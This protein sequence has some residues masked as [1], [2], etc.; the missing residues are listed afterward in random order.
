MPPALVKCLETLDVLMMWSTLE[1]RSD[2]I[3]DSRLSLCNRIQ[4]IIFHTN[5][6]LYK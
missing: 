5:F 4:T 6:Q 2:D 3:A 1:D